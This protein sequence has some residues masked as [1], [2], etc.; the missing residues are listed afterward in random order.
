MDRTQP[1]LHGLTR[2]QILAA[3]PALAGSL[4]I[5]SSGLAAPA[6]TKLHVDVCIYG[7]M[8][9]GVIAAVALARMGR[10]VAL[11]EPT[12]HLGGM[13]TGGL[14][15]VDI[16]HGGIQAFGGITGEYYR[17]V[18]EYYARTN[19]DLSRFGN[20]GVVAE[21]HVAELVLEQMLAEQAKNLTIFRESRL[22]SAHRHGRRLTSIVLDKAPVDP[23]GAPAPTPLERSYLSIAAAMFLDT[24]Y[25]GDLLA[26]AGV[27]YRC[28]RESRDEYGESL[29]GITPDSKVEF[30]NGGPLPPVDP[31]VRRGDPSSGLIPLVSGDSV[32]VP[33]ARS[34]AQ[35]AY[36][37]RLCLTKENPIPI[38][39][40]SDYSPQRFELLARTLRA[41]AAAGN[42]VRA[43]QMHEPGKERLLKFSVLPN[44]KTDVNNSGPV[45]MDFVNGG[46][47]R[48][49]NASWRERAA[50]WHAH[51]DYQRGLLHFLQTDPRVAEDIRAD[52]RQW[53]LPRDEF[54]DTRGWPTQLYIREARRMTGD[55]VMRQSDCEHPP[56][57]LPDSVGLGTYTLDSHTC[58]RLA[59]G[60]TVFS[61]GAFFDRVS[62]AYP[63]SY[64]VLTPRAADCENLLASFCVSAT[65]VCFAS[66]RMEPAFMV[67][68]ES[69]A[70]AANLALEISSSVQ[71]VNV[72]VFSRRLQNAGQILAPAEIPEGS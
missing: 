16:K 44:G 45:S 61:E 71:R 60:K 58:R 35:Q 64:R 15:W 20:S 24:S 67:L 10:S 23:R 6:A 40:G 7:G 31:F 70:I 37:F 54:R 30:A 4:L 53:G 28:D 5:R 47:E 21:P 11:V 1:Y 41:Q 65:H 68:S 2:R 39:P 32:G 9:G 50:L 62:G 66:I 72:E 26:A 48:Y 33:G 34:T 59:D 36:N 13:T 27:S 14:G 55:F 49:A 69:A 17:R 63:V 8:S 57:R 42:P 38:E 52:L 19:V 46:S 56:V 12:R 25:E 51:E 43:T 29:A 3:T 22:A 18:R